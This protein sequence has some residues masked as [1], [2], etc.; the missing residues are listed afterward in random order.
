MLVK[1][2][3][4]GKTRPLLSMLKIQFVKKTSTSIIQ[5]RVFVLKRHN[6]Y[7]TYYYFGGCK[8]TFS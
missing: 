4:H 8:N 7:K 6:M 5:S 1:Q 3:Q 2:Y